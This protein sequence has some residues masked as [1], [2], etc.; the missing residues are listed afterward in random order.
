MGFHYSFPTSRLLRDWLASMSGT[1]DPYEQKHE[2]KASY[3]KEADGVLPM[4]RFMRAIKPQDQT[5]VWHLPQDNLPRLSSK[6]ELYGT[7]EEESELDFVEDT[8]DDK[9]ADFRVDGMDD[10]AV[11][12]NNH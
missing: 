11:K 9:M 7:N 5:D 8:P 10:S 3:Y 12:E 1:S 6:I 4:F 2:E